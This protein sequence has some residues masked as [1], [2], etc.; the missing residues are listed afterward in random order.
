MQG[1]SSNRSPRQRFMSNDN[2]EKTSPSGQMISRFTGDSGQNLLL[3]VLSDESVL[4]GTPNLSHFITGCAL[5]EVPIG[6]ELIK[7][8]ES[9]NDIFIIVSGS[10]EMRVNGRR[11]TTRHVGTHIGEIALI[12]PTVRRTASAVAAEHSF[13]S[14]MYRRTLQSVCQHQSESLA[15]TSS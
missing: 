9:D 13:G 1:D 6:T 8:G 5:K 15:T 11:Q 3:E 12:D 10:F 14:E 2:E 7:Q 4:R